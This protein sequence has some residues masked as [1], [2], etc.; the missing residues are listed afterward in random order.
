MF[1][2]SIKEQHF[3]LG[4]LESKIKLFM[5]KIYV[6]VMKEIGHNI[7]R[8]TILYTKSRCVRTWCESD[9]FM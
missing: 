5:D 6:P 8:D 9:S 7:M 3:H 4:S 1:I 2:S